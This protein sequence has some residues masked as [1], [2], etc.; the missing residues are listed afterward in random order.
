MA[1]L[2]IPLS[3]AG[4]F[5]TALMA[6][7]VE[8]LRAALDEMPITDTSMPVYSNVDAAPHQSADEMRDLLSRQVIGTVRWEDSMRYLLQKGFAQF[9][10]VGPG[11]VLRGLLRRVERKIACQSVG[12]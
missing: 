3:V 9:Y 1:G 5:H 12:V 10:E 4:A 7:A 6:P 2:L 8:R 11:R